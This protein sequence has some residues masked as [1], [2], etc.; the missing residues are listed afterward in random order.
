M[1]RAVFALGA[2]GLMTFFLPIVHLAPPALGRA[3]WSAYQ[4]TTAPLAPPGLFL[5]D[6]FE[7]WS[8]YAILAI[9][10]LLLWVPQWQKVIFVSSPI[11]L[12]CVGK[13]DFDDITF[14]SSID[15][16]WPA[17]GSFGHL[18]T[19]WVLALVLAAMLYLAWVDYRI[20]TV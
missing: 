5:F 11:N 20:N 19:Y 12:W 10:L 3:D 7:Y 8:P 6:T 14:Y 18:A 1:K 9:T 4:V 17:G 13:F 2:A 15:T 16:R